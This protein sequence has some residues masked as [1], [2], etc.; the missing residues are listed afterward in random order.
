MIYSEKKKENDDF[1]QN[2][3]AVLMPLIFCG[4]FRLPY[5]SKATADTRMVLPSLTFDAMGNILI[6]LL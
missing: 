3:T 5:V 1:C 2:F 4:K 6:F